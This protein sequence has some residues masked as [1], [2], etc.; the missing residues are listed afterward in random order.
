MLLAFAALALVSP[1]LLRRNAGRSPPEERFRGRRRVQAGRVRGG[2]DAHRALLAEEYDDT[3][4]RYNLASTLIQAVSPRTG[5]RQ[6][7]RVLMTDPSEADARENHRLRR[8]LTVDKAIPRGSSQTVLN[9]LPD[10]SRAGV[11]L[12]PGSRGAF[13]NRRLSASSSDENAGGA[14]PAGR[15]VRAPRRS[16]AP[17]ATVRSPSNGA[18]ARGRSPRALPGAPAGRDRAFTAHEA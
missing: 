14:G 4:L 8:A 7:E 18:R 15:G 13:R 2:G 11:G 17:L 1:R 5:D 6:Y 16:C 12:V 9:A 10:V 3:R